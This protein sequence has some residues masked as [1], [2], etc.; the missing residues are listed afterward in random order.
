[1]RTWIR[2]KENR[3][4]SFDYPSIMGEIGDHSKT[5]RELFSPITTNPP[6]CIVLPATTAARFELKPQIIH[7]LPT[8]QD[9]KEKILICM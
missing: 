5:L 8:F 7:L 9:W 3:L 4:V 2:D 1:M 6:S